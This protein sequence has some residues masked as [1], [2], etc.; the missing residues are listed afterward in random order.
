MASKRKRGKSQQRK[1]KKGSNN[2]NNKRSKP[3][4]KQPKT[5][6]QLGPNNKEIA[7]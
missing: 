1:E 3:I 4:I 6:R 7:L 5:P 2:R